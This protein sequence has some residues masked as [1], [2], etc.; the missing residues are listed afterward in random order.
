M[1]SHPLC[2]S[3]ISPSLHQGLTDET[4]GEVAHNILVPAL[5]S[6][7]YKLLEN[8]YSDEE[9]A[10]IL[11]RLVEHPEQVYDISNQKFGTAEE[12]G[13]WDSAPAVFDS[14]LN[15]SEIAK[16]LGCV[17]NICVF[18]RD[19]EFERSEAAADIDFD[20]MVANPEQ[21]KNEAN[22]RQ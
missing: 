21:Y 11:D 20:R 19:D 8:G 10:A 6:P 16:T 17:G 13:L 9:V 1:Q 4:A 3:D 22:E 15:A 5:L 7:F 12:L 2:T 18:P 14:L